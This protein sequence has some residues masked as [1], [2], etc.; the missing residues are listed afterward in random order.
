MFL[1]SPR[2]NVKEKLSPRVVIQQEG[3][4][5]RIVGILCHKYPHARNDLLKEKRRGC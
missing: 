3:I 4:A 2:A 5:H 1:V